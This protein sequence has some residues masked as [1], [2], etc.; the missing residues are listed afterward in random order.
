M[1]QEQQTTVSGAEHLVRT[2][3]RLGVDHAF[4]IVGLGLFPLAEALYGHRDRIRY[5]SALNETNLALIANGYARAQRSAA[6]VNVY[7]ASGTALGMMAVTT[8]WAE[9]VP[10]VYTTTTS[11]RDLAGRDQ[12]AAVPRAVTEM[13]AQFVKWSCEVPNAVRIPEIL[14]RAFQ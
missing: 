12:Y 5:V 7:H 2:L 6:F 10:L 3:E 14:A 11:S 9:Q 8:A 4:N 13:S 1:A